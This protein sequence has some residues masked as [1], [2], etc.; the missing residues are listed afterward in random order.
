MIKLIINEELFINYNYIFNDVDELTNEFIIRQIP[1]TIS[2][3]ENTITYGEEPQLDLE[4]HLITLLFEKN[5][6]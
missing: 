6:F 2:S 1:L 5:S 4:N 3:L